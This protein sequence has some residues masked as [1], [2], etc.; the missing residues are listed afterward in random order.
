MVFFVYPHMF[1][2]HVQFPFVFQCL[3]LPHDKHPI[4]RPVVS[5]T[6]LWWNLPWN[7]RTG[8]LQVRHGDFFQLVDEEIAA[9]TL[10]F[11]QAGE[12]SIAVVLVCDPLMILM[13]G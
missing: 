3:A 4:P 10:I 2:F 12:K 11:L 6:F 9:A 5:E 1:Y 8:G 7:D 13:N